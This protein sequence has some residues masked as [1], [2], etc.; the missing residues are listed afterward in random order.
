MKNHNWTSDEDKAFVEFISIAKADPVYG[1]HTSSV[2][3]WPGFSEKDCFWSD[4]AKHTYTLLIIIM[5]MRKLS[6]SPIALT[7]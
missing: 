5:Q 2:G 3:Q 4:G 7:P 6:I 1:Q